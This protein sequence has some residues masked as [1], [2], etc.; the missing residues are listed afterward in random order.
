MKKNILLF[1]FLV[2]LLGIFSTTWGDL[3]TIGNSTATTNAQIPINRYYNYSTYEMLYTSSEIGAP[4]IINKVAFYKYSGSTTVT[5]NNVSIYMMISSASSLPSATVSSPYTGY[6]LVYSGSFPNTLSSGWEEVTLSSPFEYDA[7]GNL[8]I[9]VVKGYESYS[10]SRP[11][12]TYN[13]TSPTYLCRGASSD[14]SQPSS[15]SATYNRPIVRFDVSP[16][17]TGQPPNPATNPF[18]ANA[19]TNIPINVTLSW[20]SGG[21]APTDYKIF[22]GTSE[23]SFENEYSGITTTSFSPTNLQY[24]TT[25][26]WKVD[27]HNDY[28]YASD[29]AT[30]PVWSFTTMADP[31]IT[32][33]P[34]TESFDGTAFPPVGWTHQI[35][36]GATGWQRSTGSTYPTVS[37]Y[38]GAGMLYYN[39]YNLSNGSNASLFSPP[40]NAGD[41][42]MVYSTS[43]W[44]YRYKSSYSSYTDKVEIYSNT[45]PSL[46]G[47]TLLG[48]IIRDYDQAPVETGNGWYQYTFEI[49]PGAENLTYYVIFKAISN[50]G[51]NINV[52]EIS[53]ISVQGGN[54]PN[55][56][57]N[58][59]PANNATTVAITSN[60]SWSS[61]GGAP[62]GYKVYLGTD[63]GNLIEVADQPETVYDPPENLLFGNTYYWK[64]DPYNE[65]G[66]ASEVGEIPVWNFSTASGIAISPSPYNA[67][68]NQDA[69]N[70]VL[71]WAD[72]TGASGYKVKVGTSSGASDLVNMASVTES[73][74]THSSNWPYSTTIYWTVFTLNGTQEVQ[75]TEWSFTTAADPTR[76]IPYLETFDASTSLPANW[77]G[78]F[79][80]SSTHGVSSNGLYKN[81]WSS[82]TSAYVTT[83]PVGPLTDNTTLQFDYRYVEYSG[84]PATAHT[85]VAG[86]KLEIQISTD[87][88]NFTTIHTIDSSNHITSNSFATCTVPITQTKVS[89]GDVIKTKFLATWGG[90]DYYLDID[91][92]YFR[93]ISAEPVISITPESKAFGELQ[94][95][96]VSSAQVFTIKNDGGGTLTINPAIELTGTNVD[97]F[98]LTDTNSYPCEL[99][100]S[101]TM[102]ISVAFA[103]TS[104]GEKTASLKIVDNLSKTEHNIPLTGTG[105]DYSISV[106]YLNDFQSNINGWTI[107]D[108]NND[109]KKWTLTD[110]ISPNKAMKIVYNSSLA[111]NDWFIT[112]PIS[113]TKDT[114]YNIRYEYRI[115]S[116]TYPENLGV[117]IGSSPT[118]GALTTLLDDQ[119]PLTNEEFEIGTAS[120]T[121]QTTGIYYIGFYGYSDQDQFNLYV[122]NFRITVTG[123]DI[124]SGITS[125]GT[126]N[127]DP[128]PINNPVTGNPLDT[129][130]TIEGITGTPII[131]VLTEWAPPTVELPNAGL[132]FVLSGTT[133]SGTTI[134]INHNLG[135]VPAQIAYR[136]EPGTWNLLTSSSP[137][138]NN[139]NAT[140]VTFTLSG[141]AAGDLGFV[142]PQQ[143]GQTLPVTLSN[144]TAVVTSENFVNIAWMAE[145]E[146]NHSGY[147]IFRNETKDLENAVK[148]NAQ[149]IDKGTAVGTQISY[150]YTDFEVYTNMMYYYWLESV[151][152]DGSSQFY[153]P[154]TVTIGDPAQEPLPPVVPMVTK[155][156]NAFPNPFNPNTNI[157]YSLKEVGKV[158]IEIY[159]MK[160]QKIKT[161]TQ[162]HNSPG[163]YQVSWDGRD[164]NGRSVASGIYL[165]RLTTANYTSAKKMVLAK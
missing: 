16:L 12:Y 116:D 122:D 76:S 156:Y 73:Q 48:T 105:A 57:I 115:E 85:L 97:Q 56:A 128:A 30:L 96:T 75:G 72:V 26:Y 142:F 113:L 94:I 155:L 157:R 74:Y 101:E 62:T 131:T 98:Q 14:G 55:P 29:I 64:V 69:T 39:S 82:S 111:M 103:P 44:M 32:E 24:S 28:G 109:G 125:G 22:W 50:Y 1:S 104:L 47:A 120:F 33:F 136:I 68:T 150:F 129:S 158:K 154:L 163:Y 3:I 144:F 143:E 77:T 108:V 138:V 90:G 147:N 40:I 15:L 102:T 145:T 10:S 42:N 41:A 2:I 9:L 130:L 148:I 11:Y 70:R 45:T 119:S 134:T 79:S 151:A 162:E 54:P 59:S 51:Y 49:G 66:S 37:P 132:T 89:Q 135:F 165:Y 65:Y 100:S 110:E 78:S 63:Q 67:A 87:G 5:I 164:E 83:P 127:P 27:P 140:T 61:G 52:D 17:V 117:Y 133:F 81:L 23:T 160:G 106:P 93:H 107:L 99:G 86:D 38:S 25:Y 20:S 58:P 7:S 4:Y 13:S 159:N 46:T 71:N 95:N 118:P 18:P 152:L 36:S 31:T 84:Y 8:H 114:T 161:F 92:V 149:L 80:V 137:G 6:S 141:K 139:W 19:S 112:P 121:P 35:G 21:G 53:F 60:L 123:S 153:G 43:F 126:A 88:T 124:V 34:H 91:N 146:T